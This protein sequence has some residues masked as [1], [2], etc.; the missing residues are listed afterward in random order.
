MSKDNLGSPQEFGYIL[1]FR[2]PGY[3][4]A[5]ERGEYRLVLIDS[6]RVPC[7]WAPE[8]LLHPDHGGFVELR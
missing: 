8:R 5:R 6:R 2:R 4:R 1:D 3:A 7:S